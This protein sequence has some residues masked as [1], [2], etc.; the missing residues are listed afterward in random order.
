MTDNLELKK[1]TEALL[2]ALEIYKRKYRHFATK[3]SPIFPLDREL[4]LI[5]MVVRTDEENKRQ[6]ERDSYC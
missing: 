6:M 5:L 2:D 1:D 4:R 3:E